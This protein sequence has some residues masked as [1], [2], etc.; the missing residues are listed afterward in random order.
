MVFKHGEIKLR[1]PSQ[2]QLLDTV[3]KNTLHSFHVDMVN[4]YATDN[5][6]AYSLDKAQIGKK[7]A[8]GFIMKKP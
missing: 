1:E 5:V 7:N 2:Y 6:I 8:G 3:V 4:I